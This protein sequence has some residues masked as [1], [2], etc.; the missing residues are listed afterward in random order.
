MLNYVEI[1]IDSF[2]ALVVAI[3]LGI[4]LGSIGSYLGFLVVT[5]FVGYF[6]GEDITNGAI[7]G[8]FISVIAGLIFTVSMILMWIF[9]AGGLGTS[10]L[11]FGLSGIIIGLIIDAII[12][13][14]GGSL[15]AL[16]NY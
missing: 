13:S 6:S 4:F 5:F 15:G 11:E 2:L 7:K 8:I 16:I 3:V 12:G 9:T 1:I 10:M 14:I